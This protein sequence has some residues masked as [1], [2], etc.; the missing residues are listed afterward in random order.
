MTLT[1]ITLSTLLV[2]LVQSP[3]SH[4]QSDS[5][6]LS[7]QAQ[8][9]MALESDWSALYGAKDIDGIVALLAKDSVL[10][11][12]GSQP[13]VGIDEIRQA[14]AD[15]LATDDSVSW[16]SLHAVISPSGDM[17]YDYGAAATVLADG[18]VIEG[19]Y[20]VVWVK[21]DGIW[22]VAADMFN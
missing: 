4:G 6:E 10:I 20:L 12:P 5:A 3:I 11:M 9:I 21:E 1:Q 13:I 17:A 2:A 19:N 15:M 7:A 18:T 8:E 14:T 16:R 22:K